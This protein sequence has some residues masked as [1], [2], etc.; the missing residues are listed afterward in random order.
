MVGDRPHHL[1]DGRSSPDEALPELQNLSLAFDPTEYRYDFILTGLS[2][3]SKF[4]QVISSV[5]LLRA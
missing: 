3:S 2:T 5:R 4:M 1:V